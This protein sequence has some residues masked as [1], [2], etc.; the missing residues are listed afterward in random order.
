MYTELYMYTATLRAKL[1]YLINP[2]L[3]MCIKKL[4]LIT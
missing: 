1:K 3:Y 2:Y 4:K